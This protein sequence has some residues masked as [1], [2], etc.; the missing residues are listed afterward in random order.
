VS[1]DSKTSYWSDLD[2]LPYYY[3]V[4]TGKIYII[5]GP[6][7]SSQ[8][9]PKIIYT[10]FK[11]LLPKELDMKRRL[12]LIT[13]DIYLIKE[14]AMRYPFLMGRSD[15][16]VDWSN[17]SL[18]G[19]NK[20]KRSIFPL[21]T[22][23]MCEHSSIPGFYHSSIDS[24]YDSKVQIPPI[25]FHDRKW[26]NYYYR[27]DGRFFYFNSITQ[28]YVMIGDEFLEI[29]YTNFNDSRES[30]K[31]KMKKILDDYVQ[32]LQLKYETRTEF[33]SSL[34]EEPSWVAEAERMTREELRIKELNEKEA[35]RI[36]EL[37]ENRLC[38]IM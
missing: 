35:L 33:K 1:E 12:K 7:E 23:S 26:G 3:E 9:L 29:D 11:N 22:Y 20:K 17:N 37:N 31:M 4:D 10:G 15:K 30:I 13:D 25:F 24:E 19:F 16:I 34:S 5:S 18:K 38:V 2:W 6:S 36:K 27:I 28:A 14:E 32:E 21:Y 8:R